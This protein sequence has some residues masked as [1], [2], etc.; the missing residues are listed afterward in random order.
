MPP[1]YLQGWNSPGQAVQAHVV[2]PRPPDRG[3]QGPCCY[4]PNL[5]ALGMSVPHLGMH[6]ARSKQRQRL[7]M[8]THAMFLLQVEVEVHIGL[9]ASE[10]RPGGFRFVGQ[11]CVLH[12]G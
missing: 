7:L 5:T 11:C 8:R 3:P 12:C 10:V 1:E 6:A 4:H 9:Y 2:R